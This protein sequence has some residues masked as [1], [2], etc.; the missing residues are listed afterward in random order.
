MMG[1][2]AAKAELCRDRRQRNISGG[3]PQ[4]SCTAQLTIYV[5]GYQN[6]GKDSIGKLLAPANSETTLS[7]RPTYWS[8][9]VL[10]P[11][12]RLALRGQ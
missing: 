4:L 3:Q 10:R 2:H 11:P 7:R 5:S 12:R 6:T 9:Y 8:T 1:V